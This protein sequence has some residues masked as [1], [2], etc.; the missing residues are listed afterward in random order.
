[1]RYQSLFLLSS[2]LFDFLV[3]PEDEFLGLAKLKTLCELQLI[4]KI[5]FVCNRMRNEHFAYREQAAKLNFAAV[6]LT[7]AVK[8][9]IWGSI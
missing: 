2:N 7:T 5:Y 8:V 6:A 4:Q 9:S 3:I 1:M